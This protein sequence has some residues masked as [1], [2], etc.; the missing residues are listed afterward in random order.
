[1]RLASCFPERFG[2][3]LLDPARLDRAFG[4]AAEGQNLLHTFT[5]TGQGDE[6]AHND[7]AVPVMGSMP[8]TT[9]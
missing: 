6:V 8:M 4:G 1:M 9:P 5:T 3:V 7:I 2:F